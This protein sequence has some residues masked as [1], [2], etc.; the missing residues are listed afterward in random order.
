[1]LCLF[2]ACDDSESTDQT[3]TASISNQNE[4]NVQTDEEVSSESDPEIDDTTTDIEEGTSNTEEETTNNTEEDTSNTEE[5]TTNNTNETNTET[6]T[7]VLSFTPL[8]EAGDVVSFVD[9]NRYMGIWYEIATTPSFQQR[10]CYET[11][12]Q[13]VFNEAAGW[14]DVTN[15]C[16]AGSFSARIQEIQGKAEIADAD[17]QAKLTVTFF[18]Q[19]APYWVVELDGS[20]GDEPYQWAVV[21]VPNKQTMWILS[22]TIELSEQ[23]RSE[24]EMKLLARGFPIDRLIDTPQIQP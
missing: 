5:D 20:E 14:V 16:K 15:R 23:Q 19:G 22:R 21:S 8:S 7:T 13:Y 9:I 24:I 12:A 6:N 10:S 11:Q 4:A 17:T 2:Q 1:M 18:N 3:N